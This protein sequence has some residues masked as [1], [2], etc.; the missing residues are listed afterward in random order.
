MFYSNISASN[1]D[2]TFGPKEPDFEE[3]SNPTTTTLK[4]ITL[5]PTTTRKT[6]ITTTRKPTAVPTTTKTTSRPTTTTGWHPT[7]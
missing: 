2:V 6:T 1:C 7:I 3:C 4:P 5:A